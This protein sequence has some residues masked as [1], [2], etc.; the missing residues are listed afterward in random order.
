MGTRKHC[1]TRTGHTFC[2]QEPVWPELMTFLPASRRVSSCRPRCTGRAWA[3]GVFCQSLRACLLLVLL[4]KCSFLVNLVVSS[5]AQVPTDMQDTRRGSRQWLSWCEAVGN[6]TW[7][8]GWCTSLPL[9]AQKSP[10]WGGCWPEETACGGHYYH[11]HMETNVTENVVTFL[12]K[13][14]PI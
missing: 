6:T 4:Y 1:E 7:N 14:F 8:F 9:P 5:S 3:R 13:Q 10:C 12:K 11:G 2:K